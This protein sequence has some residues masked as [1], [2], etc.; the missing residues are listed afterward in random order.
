MILMQMAGMALT[1][2]AAPNPTPTAVPGMDTVANLFLGWGKWVLIVGGVLGLFICGGMMILG[3][4]NR[5]ATAVDGATGI[6]WVLGGLTLGA[7]AAGVVDM[8]LK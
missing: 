1:V 6:P 3:R 2:L 4:R 8:L 7:I 5:S